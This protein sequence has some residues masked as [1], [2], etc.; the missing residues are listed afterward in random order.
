[1]N[2]FL[3]F[4]CS[5]SDLPAQPLLPYKKCKASRICRRTW[6]SPL[7]SGGPASMN[8]DTALARCSQESSLYRYGSQDRLFLTSGEHSC[9]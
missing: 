9:S 8:S 7:T 1:M 4:L 2:Q 5:R 3:Y 6:H